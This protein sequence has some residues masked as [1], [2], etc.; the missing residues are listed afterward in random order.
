MGNLVSRPKGRTVMRIFRPK[1][2]DVTGVKR[3]DVVRSSK[4][5]LYA[6]KFKDWMG[7][8]C[9]T[10]GATIK[11]LSRWTEELRLLG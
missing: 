3:D 8:V 7:E 2:E 6:Y 1:T 11:I 10:H 4:T 9:S 5:I